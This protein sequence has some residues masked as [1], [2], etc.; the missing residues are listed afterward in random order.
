M[1]DLPICGRLF[2]WYRGDGVSMSHLDRF[3]LSFNWCTAWPNCIQ[4]AN[5]RGL[6]DYVPLE[7]YADVD[8][9]GPRPLRMLKCWADF[10]GYEQFV[11][12]K[13]GSYNIEGWGA[14][15]LKEKLKLIKGSL[16]EWHQRHSRNLIGK[17]NT[18]KER[19]SILDIK[20][21]MSTLDDEEVSE[22]QDLS[23][24]LRSLSRVQTSISWQQ[25]RLKWL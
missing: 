24:N 10:P 14:F 18:V 11:R 23:L 15:V 20:G 19:M 6:S 9:W 25:A 7:L 2:T 16:R 5:Q 4:L 17:C 12:E 13:W 22:L 1:I 3:L 21:E 8:N